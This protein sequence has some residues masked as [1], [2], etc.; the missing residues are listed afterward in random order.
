[1]G[2][3]SGGGGIHDGCGKCVKLTL[4]ISN[5]LILI[6]GIVV[7]AV[8]IWTLVDKS[9]IETLLGNELYISSANIMIAAGCVAIVLSFLGGYGAY[10]EIKCMLLTYFILVL[11]IFVI[12][13]IGGVLGY[14]FR[15][16]IDDNLRPTM[17]HAI[18][19]YDPDKPLDSIT[20]AW[21]L[22]QSK[23]K[24]CGIGMEGMSAQPWRAW[25]K[26]QRINS[27]QAESKV[28]ASCCRVV[29]GKPTDCAS[30]S[31]DETKLDLIYTAD[32][33]NMG[34]DFVKGH[35]VVLGAI[36]IGIACIMIL[37]MVFSI[38]LFKLIE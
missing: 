19:N 22:T 34:L 17:L 23:L 24:C 3:G 12:L 5:L 29:D 20:E 21:D 25:R 18:E 9:Y 7:L 2:F 4:I 6:G 28:P 8:G 33:F 16:Q 11:L 31:I 38:V 30:Q 36:A 1:M 14:V 37:G 26:N 35:A 27:G 13:L 10:K 15:Y 32:C